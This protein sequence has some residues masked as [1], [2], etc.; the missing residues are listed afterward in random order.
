MGPT[1]A[2]S[3]AAAP[4]SVNHSGTGTGI[5]KTS[6]RSAMQVLMIF[7]KTYLLLKIIVEAATLSDKILLTQL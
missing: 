2:P 4:L 6:E 5:S 7:L 3:T 1:N